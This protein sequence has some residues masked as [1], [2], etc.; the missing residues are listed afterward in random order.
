MTY[1][2]TCQRAAL[3]CLA[4]PPDGIAR[5]KYVIPSTDDAIRAYGGGHRGSDP[6]GRRHLDGHWPCPS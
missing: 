3:E 2:C 1:T 4:A 6:F 5:E